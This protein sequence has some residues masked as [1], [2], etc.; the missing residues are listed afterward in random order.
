MGLSPPAVSQVR[1]RPRGFGDL[2]YDAAIT[3]A[4]PG[5][6]QSASPRPGTQ[7]STC[8]PQCWA[9]PD[10]AMPC[11]RPDGL[12][13]GLQIAGFAGEDAGFF[14]V[15]AAKGAAGCDEASAIF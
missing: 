12:P 6:L 9:F 15:A 11:C 1:T 3:L 4:A 14:A 8:P 10:L 5:V 2:P 13:L 7:C